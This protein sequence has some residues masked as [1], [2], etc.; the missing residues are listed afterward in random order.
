LASRRR[1]RR[2]GLL[3]AVRLTHLLGLLLTLLR[4]YSQ[5]RHC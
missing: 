1:R 2:L 3:L 5:A 4:E